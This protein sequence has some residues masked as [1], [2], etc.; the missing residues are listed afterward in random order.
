MS[1]M[2]N[3]PA[4]TRCAALALLLLAGCE[5]KPDKSPPPPEPR[6]SS[7][8]ASA[9]KPPQSAAPTASEQAAAPPPLSGAAFAGTWQGAYDAK[10]GSVVVPPSVK[11]KTHGADDG[12]AM[13]GQ[14][15][16]EIT[17]S[18][19][20]EVKG[21]A[22]GALGEATLTGKIDD[23]GLLGVSWFPDDPTKP[24]A[25]TGVL[26]GVFK[27]SVI[28]AKIRVAGPDATIVRESP[29]DLKRK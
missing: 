12:K 25:M 11:D 14:G 15:K 23:T 5:S 29:L 17:I 6:P 21:T 10:K 24:N 19:S 3:L 1:L 8:A 2:D 13:T 7:P 18:P 16:V 27:E 28:H 4:Q 22:T 20:G 26:T 9:A